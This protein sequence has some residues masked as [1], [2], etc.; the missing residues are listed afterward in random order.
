MAF[1]KPLVVHSFTA[2]SAMSASSQQYIFVKL[3]TDEKVCPVTA[4]SDYPIGVLQNSPG[5]GEQAQVLLAGIS[6]VRVGATDIA[7]V[8]NAFIAA[9][10]TARAALA[11]SGASATYVAGRVISMEGTDN[12]A[13]LVTAIINCMTLGTLRAW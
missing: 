4:A 13:A 8:T 10:A 12:D 3:L 7:S 5:V 1:E 6:K 9:D 11:A 2:A